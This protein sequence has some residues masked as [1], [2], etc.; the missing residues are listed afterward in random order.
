MSDFKLKV[1]SNIAI[2]HNNIKFTK[3]QQDA[4]E[5]LITWTH[6]SSKLLATLSGAAGTGKSTIIDYFIKNNRFKSGIAVTAT[7]H[8]ASHNIKKITNTAVS[9]I[10]KLL[11]LRLDT[12]LDNFDI[13]NLMFSQMGV[14]YIKDYNLVIID[15]SSM[16][17]SN[18]FLHIRNLSLEYGVKILFVGDEY[19]LPPV[20]ELFSPCFK[21]GNVDIIVK[22]TEIVRQVEG[23]PLLEILTLSRND[24]KNNDS[25]LIRYL[26]KNKTKNNKESGYWVLDN[27]NFTSAIGKAFTRQDF[28]DDNN[29]CRF[30]AYTNSNISI[31]NKY[32][33]NNI[34]E[35]SKIITNNDLLTSY[36][37][38]VD[39]FLNPIIINSEDYDVIDFVRYTKDTGVEG[40]LCQLFNK[41]TNEKT[42]YLFIVDHTDRDNYFRFVHLIKNKID[43]CYRTKKWKSEFYPLRQEYISLVDGYDINKK[44]I[45]SKDMDHGYGLTVHKTQG[46]TYDNIFINLNN[47]VYDDY[48]KPRGDIDVRNRLIYVAL[49]R[50]RYKAIINL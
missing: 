26:Y 2:S 36:I 33:R 41:L 38:I 42:K 14:P 21:Q 28:K 46:S 29:F 23:N 27:N 44:F 9:T 8:K 34:F 20:N 45:F 49:S 32:I 48:N 43:E 19:Q 31:W 15:E 39:E 25:S 12:N 16:L 50:S 1:S 22:L 18:L 11:G 37:T 47:I 35:D 3:S 5:T 13:N 6:D 40:Y 24:V 4:L 10:H 7:T 30:T 17:N